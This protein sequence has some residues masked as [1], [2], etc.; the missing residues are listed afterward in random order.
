MDM[1]KIKKNNIQKSI[2]DEIALRKEL[3]DT[4]KNILISAGAGAGKTELMS[5]AVLNRLNKNQELQESQVV[6]I[7][8][9]NAAAEELRDRINIRYQEFRRKDK[10]FREINT[11]DIVIST[12][13]SFC[14][15]LVRQRAF[16]C[17]FG[18]AP[19]YSDNSAGNDDEMKRFI[20]SFIDSHNKE[21][22]LLRK[23]WGYN[24]YKVIWESFQDIA[25]KSG[26]DIQDTPVVLKDT[27]ER[28]STIER[29]TN[30]TQLV[31]NQIVCRDS[32]RLEKHTKRFRAFL[33]DR[34]RWHELINIVKSLLE[35]TKRKKDHLSAD[36]LKIAKEKDLPELLKT[37]T[38]DR[39]A[40]TIGFLKNMYKDWHD[41]SRDTELNNNNILF[42]TLQLLEK[43]EAVNF[44]K[45]KY[46][47]FFV[48]EFQ[49][50]DYLQIQILLKLCTEG[51]QD[52]F[53]LRDHSVFLVGDQ[54]QSIYRFKG[55]EVGLYDYMRMKYFENKDNAKFYELVMNF[56]SQKEIVDSVN[57][58][59]NSN[60]KFGQAGIETGTNYKDMISASVPENNDVEDCTDGGTI[61]AGVEGYIKLDVK[62]INTE[63]VK[64]LLELKNKS[65]CL[66]VREKNDA[67]GSI[68]VK[69]KTRPVQWS[70]FLILTNF[71][72]EAAAVYN[73]IKKYGIPV[74]V[75][76]DNNPAENRAICR[77]RA[78]I[79]YMQKKSPLHLA[80]LTASFSPKSV[81]ANELFF[82]KGS[83]FNKFTEDDLKSVI[84]IISEIDTIYHKKGVMAVLY[85]ALTQGWLT[86]KR[87]CYTDLI[88]QLPLLYQFFEGLF[89][90]AED[91][92]DSV[93]HYMERFTNKA[94]KRVLNPSENTDCV[95]VMNFHQAKG[96]EGNIVINIFIN[97]LEEEK[98]RNE[99]DI[100]SSFYQYLETNEKGEPISILQKP[101]VWLTL[102]ETI[103]ENDGYHKKK[104]YDYLDDEQ[105]RI[106]SYTEN[107]ETIRKRYVRNTRARV[108]EYNYLLIKEKTKKDSSVSEMEEKTV[109]EY[110]PQPFSF[111]YEAS[112]HYISTSPSRLEVNAE[113]AVGKPAAPAETSDTTDSEK[114]E[115]KRKQGGALYGTVM[116]RA[117]ELFL[118]ARK[119]EHQPTE[120]EL[121]NFVK[122]AILE[123]NS[124]D[125][126]A[127]DIFYPV[128]NNLKHFAQ[129]F[130][131]KYGKCETALETPL[132]FVF[133]KTKTDRTNSEM[134]RLIQQNNP[135]TDLDKVLFTGFSDLIVF[136]DNSASVIDYKS[137]KDKPEQDFIIRY[138]S[139]QKAYIL[140]LDSLLDGMDKNMTLYAAQDS[141]WIIRCVI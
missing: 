24:A 60:G 68:T 109:E 62:T 3:E 49:D 8:F 46:K 74:V 81:A 63:L 137:D 13:H 39:T 93:D 28:I 126:K 19:I 66:V 124:E 17:G 76:G 20:R 47:V 83:L 61:C 65:I 127:F 21:Y 88:S 87:V 84:D 59:Y 75:A 52:D 140:C 51:K 117:F 133:D 141:Q 120:K 121:A 78:I 6:V 72:K 71:K 40:V 123:N 33:E 132:Y 70:D 134:L 45:K 42:K 111:S 118:K 38:D 48:D 64:K 110:V 57:K 108:K 94:H 129:E 27:D 14:A 116:H 119:L 2:E 99:T 7:T 101:K 73:E 16:D 4:D 11:D 1:E 34:S 91:H 31:I 67:N 138:E 79:R 82:E 122:Q 35:T 18:V 12:I 98:N 90:Q 102:I 130:T 125:E 29:L 86:D 22:S 115:E 44:F 106:V 139:Q 135:E 69:Y 58:N 105:R 80:E 92:I 26:L 41:N 36:E 97:T 136:G 9:T 5:R 104:F 23:Y 32:D 10:D 55:A 54:K 30:G 37:L 50:T 95:R 53:K 85:H 103:V 107:C 128:L 43:E 77:L 96:L 89:S 131:D 114:R 100:R 112:R 25:P 113:N 15:G 56:R